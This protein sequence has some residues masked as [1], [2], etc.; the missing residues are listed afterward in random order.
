MAK[1]FFNFRQGA[2][3]QIDDLGCE[4]ASVEEAYLGAFTAAQDMWRELLI[5]REDPFLCAFEVMD[6]AGRDLF[7]L[8]FGE[9][10]DACRGRT[11]SSMPVK[12]HPPF[13]QQ[14][15]QSH[16]SALRSFDEVYS[17]VAKTRATLRESWHLLGR[18]SQIAGE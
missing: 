8:P 17:T 6:E 4:F 3:Y 1:F 13:I 15:L 10:L 2:A 18:A 14:A 5:K 16:Q 12:P 9:V 11:S 7:V